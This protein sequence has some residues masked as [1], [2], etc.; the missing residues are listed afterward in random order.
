MLCFAVTEPSSSNWATKQCAKESPCTIVPNSFATYGLDLYPGY[1]LMDEMDYLANQALCDE[2][3]ESLPLGEQDINNPEEYVIAAFALAVFV[4][5]A[6]T[7]EYELRPVP[8][9]VAE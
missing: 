7:N 6:A 9:S 2:A 4:Y 1:A 5:V 8:D 3:L